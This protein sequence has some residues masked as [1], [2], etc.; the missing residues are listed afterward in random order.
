VDP[1]KIPTGA[2]DVTA[3]GYAK[4]AV[5]EKVLAPGA[6]AGDN[7]AN[8]PSAKNG[9]KSTYNAWGERSGGVVQDSGGEGSGVWGGG[10]AMVASLDFEWGDV[11]FSLFLFPSLTQPPSYF[12]TCLTRHPPHNK[13]HQ[14]AVAGRRLQQDSSVAIIGPSWHSLG[15]SANSIRALARTGTCYLKEVR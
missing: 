5:A 12:N 6:A 11:I 8:A 7:A 1:K 10:V 14:N 13:H 2:E 3:A 15:I 9:Y 4:R